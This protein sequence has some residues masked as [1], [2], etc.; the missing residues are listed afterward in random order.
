[1]R[2]SW[3]RCSR[4]CVMACQSTIN[5]MLRNMSLSNSRSPG[6]LP[7]V[8][9]TP[10]CMACIAIDNASSTFCAALAIF[11]GGCP[12]NNVLRTFPTVWC[13]LSHTAL[14]CGFFAVGHTSLIWQFCNSI[15]NTG[16]MNSV[17]GSCT[18]P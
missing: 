16:P 6:R 2:F 5:G 9:R 11:Y 10:A 7:K 4:L 15:W 8:E 3:I 13:I 17:P 12:C 1:M 14:D 18:Q